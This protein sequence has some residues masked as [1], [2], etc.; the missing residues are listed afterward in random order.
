MEV[1]KIEMV[2]SPVVDVENET[3][4]LI[5]NGDE[6]LFLIKMVD[7]SIHVTLFTERQVHIKSHDGTIMTTSHYQASPW[8][9]IRKRRQNKRMTNEEK[10]ERRRI[11]E[12]R[13]KLRELKR[14][15]DIAKLKEKENGLP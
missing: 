3:G 15:M 13:R 11:R 9:N 6:K 12:E 1:S 7:D 5:T 10:A 8:F 4:M 14:L 2:I